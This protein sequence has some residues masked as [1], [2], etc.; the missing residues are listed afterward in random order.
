MTFA[1][2]RVLITGGGSGAGAD[3]ARG[4][5]GAGAEVVIAEFVAENDNGLA[6]ADGAV[7]L[8]AAAG[9][10]L[11]KRAGHKFGHGHAVV[12]CGPSGQ[13]GAARMTARGR[14]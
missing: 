13:G 11:A 4:F 6:D 3:L 12:V 8:T 7:R 14:K 2:K 10:R 9:R 5:A 1:A